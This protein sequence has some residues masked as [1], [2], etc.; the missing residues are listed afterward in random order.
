[1][2][3]IT[4]LET[5]F[6]TAINAAVAGAEAGSWPGEINEE[7]LDRAFHNTPVAVYVVFADARPAEHPTFKDRHIDFTFTLAIAAKSARGATD[8]AGGAYAALDAL[9]TA[10]QGS[11]LGLVIQPL[12]W[13]GEAMQVSAE[14]YVVYKQEW[15]VAVGK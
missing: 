12:R 3:T 2:Y 5:A 8:A 4:A 10:L 11:K 15:I 13:K 1:M 7:M 6:I 14:T 9:R